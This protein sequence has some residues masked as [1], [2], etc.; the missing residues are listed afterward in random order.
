MNNDHITALLRNA[1]EAAG[2][3]VRAEYHLGSLRVEFSTSSPVYWGY[4]Q[5]DAAT[6]QILS[7]PLAA[8][9]RHICDYFSTDHDRIHSYWRFRLESDLNL[10]LSMAVKKKS[11]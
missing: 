1:L 3:C 6:D 7:S 2:L 10:D 9:G 11:K 4:T 5:C 8:T